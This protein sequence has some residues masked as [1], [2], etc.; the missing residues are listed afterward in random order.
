MDF[1]RTKSQKYIQ[2]ITRFRDNTSTRNDSIRSEANK[3]TLSYQHGGA[4]SERL[5]NYPQPESK[6]KAL[7]EFLYSLDKSRTGFVTQ[8]NF[9]KVIRVFG[10][11]MPSATVLSQ[12]T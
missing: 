7:R 9:S 2:Q 6:V 3:S 10:H 11:Q 5:L 12:H 1:I 4:M 8:A